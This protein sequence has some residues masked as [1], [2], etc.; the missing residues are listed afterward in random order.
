MRLSAENLK[1]YIDFLKEKVLSKHIARPFFYSANTIFFHIS[2]KGDK[3][4]VISL[5]D[6][7]PRFYS[8][9]NEIDVRGKDSKFIDQ[10][11]K[12]MNN[13]F[14]VDMEAVNDDKILK[15]SLTII[16]SVFKEEGRTLYF[17]M[18]PRHPN[19]ILTDLNDKVILSYRPGELTDPRPLLKGMQYVYPPKMEFPN[20]DM[21][22]TAEKYLDHCLSLESQLTE[23]RKKDRFG[24]IL[25]AL[26]SKEKSLRR[27]IESITKDA[28]EAKNHL[29]DGRFGHAIYTCYSDIPA[30]AT[31]FE[32]E[33][34]TIE[35][36]P[37]KPLAKNAELY[38]KKAKKSK[39]SIIM[40]D[41]YVEKAK[42][43][44]EDV[45][46]ALEQIKYADEAGLETLEKELGL[47]GKKTPGSKKI[48]GAFEGLSL[49]TIPYQVEY[50]GTRI[51]FGKT[52]KQNDCLTFLFGTTKTH[53][54]LH[55]MGD[56]GSHIVIKKDNPSKDE[57][58]I[59]AEIALLNSNKV[60][61]EVMYTLRKNVRKG[62]AMG[63]AIVKEFDI[64]R[65]ND[66]S[67]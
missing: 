13:S 20:E 50:K 29:E 4:F 7:E 12:E 48:K 47:G 36:D 54:W 56:S 42:K 22:F 1:I 25:S 32:Y 21:N 60:D 6:A 43:E 52:S 53:V 51:L 15:M 2:G 17:E 65:I 44:L 28:E 37:L 8:T 57:I 30:N 14:V 10:L 5:D 58:R 67:D 3:R 64:I 38:Y 39:Q 23:R 62:N 41:V 45:V 31:S 59:A 46:S 55:V 40:C 19:L 26:K 9:K 34:E 61:G 18:I 35:L 49:A 16:N 33:G 63:Q 66:I 11:A 27:K 24:Y